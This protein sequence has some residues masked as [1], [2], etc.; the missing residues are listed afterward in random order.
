[1]RRNNKYGG[2]HGRKN[3]GKMILA[4]L[5][6]VVIVVSLGYFFWGDHNLSLAIFPRFNH[7]EQV[8]S[9]LEPEVELIIEEAVSLEPEVVYTGLLLPADATT[10]Q[11]QDVSGFDTLAF[12]AKDSTGKFYYA[13]ENK[14]AVYGSEV[15][16]AKTNTPYLTE[17]IAGETDCIAM[18]SVLADPLYTSYYVTASALMSN[19]GYGYKDDNG[20][21]WLDPGKEDAQEW[22]LS[23]VVELIAMGVDELLLTEFHYPQ[24]GDLESIRYS[25]EDPTQALTD[26]L[27]EI[28][29]RTQT[30][31]VSLGMEMS[32]GALVS[33]S[34]PYEDWTGFVDVFYAATND[35]PTAQ[36]L[37]GDDVVVLSEQVPLSGSYLLTP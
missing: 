9:E 23:L 16:T 7:E 30:A 33:G 1:M 36:S 31:G 22:V 2:Y 29:A 15:E 32:P 26:L 3:Y 12:M 4:L 24:T 6:I 35:L 28:Y 18:L 8:E 19:R 37:V 17:L 11:E 21:V 27:A 13:T 20:M 5:L 10:W 34:V 25:A 14:D